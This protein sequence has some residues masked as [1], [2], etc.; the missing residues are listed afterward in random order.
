MRWIV[1]LISGVVMLALLALG[2][3]LLIPTEEIARRAAA[4]VE[5]MTGRSLTI[6]G[7]VKARIW[8]RLAVSTGRIELANADW[9]ADVPLLSAESLGIEL[10]TAALIGGSIR[11]TGLDL[12]APQIR[13]E[14]HRDGRVNWDLAP[15]GGVGGTAGEGGGGSDITL[16]EARLRDGSFS[17]IDH[18][19]GAQHSASAI[20]ATLQLPDMAAAAELAMT[21]RLNGQ[22]LDISLNAAPAA[23]LLSGARANG[24]LALAVGGSRLDFTGS[25]GH[26]PLQLDG[27]LHLDAADR[28]ALAALI[29][30]PL[31]ELPPGFGARVVRLDGRAVLGA[32]QRLALRDALLVLDDTRLRLRADLS[33]AGA[34]PRIEGSISAEGPLRLPAGG[35]SDSGGASTGWS[36]A[37]IN[38]SALHALDAEVEFSAPGINAS[39][40]NSGALRGRLALADGR[41]VVTLS[42]LAAYEGRLSG[43]V[44]VNGRGRGSARAD[45]VVEGVALQPLLRD[46]A[47]YDRL[48]A[49][50]DGKL[51]LLSSAASV[52]EMMQR[53]E[54]S[55]QISLGKGELRGLDLVGMLRNL[56]PGYVG[57]GQST[58]FDGIDTGPFSIAEGILRADALTLRA[59]YLRAEGRG[60]IGIAGRTLDYRVIPTALQNADGTGGVTV[61]LMITGSWAAPRYRLD[62]EALARPKIEAE[63]ARAEE[64]AKQEL[65]RQVERRLGVSA[66]EGETLEDAAKR[67]LEE[68]VRR[69]LGR[70]LGGN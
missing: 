10:D 16:A 70:L 64:R 2:L 44:V 68:E 7:P 54:G 41:A 45:L 46:V 39:G 34:R 47:G 17:L 65:A 61:P 1:R 30:Q 56:D 6:A 5:A 31:P 18:A 63:R 24:K 23:A 40:L 55:G 38:L 60:T 62:L 33:T 12:A 26:A 52:A 19:S 57:A 49:R 4:Q 42:E 8:P 20:N 69:G 36:T 43:T 29:G 9:A 67:R 58:I 37:P 14:R 35:S 13:L 15:A 25:F 22:A 50:A 3:V 48:I 59:P 66:Q 28:P 21:A 11:I 53:L 27:A 32:D 51:S